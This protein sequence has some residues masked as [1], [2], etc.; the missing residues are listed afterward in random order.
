MVCTARADIDLRVE[1]RPIVQAI[2]AYVL[3][4]DGE[5]PIAGLA[6]GDFS[7]TLDGMA[8]AEYEFS[9]PPSQDPSQN[10]SIV[11]VAQTARFPSASVYNALIDELDVGDYVSVVKYQ[12][13]I[14]MSRSG[15]VEILAFT[16]VD[17]G[18]GSDALRAFLQS[19]LS[20]SFG[21]PV[22]FYQALLA[23]VGEFERPA[24]SLPDGPK[25]IV[26]AA[27]GGGFNSLSEVIASANANS[28][29]I[30]NVGYA[31]SDPYPDSVARSRSLAENTGGFRVPLP[32]E[33]S[34][35]GALAIMASWLENGYRITIP[36]D[37]VTDCNP[38]VL[39]V[40]TG[41]E[42]TNITF[43]RCDTTP[44]R[45]DFPWMQD[46]AVGTKVVSEAAIITGI[47]TAVPVNVLDGE[48]SIGCGSTF[49]SEPGWILPGESVC[50]RHTTAA[51]GGLEV[52]TLLIVGGEAAWFT[53]STILPASP[54]S[55]PP[56][57]PP[58]DDDDFRRRRWSGGRRGTPDVVGIAI[59]AAAR[60]SRD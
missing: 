44:E 10:V 50:L 42:T 20:Q 59:C 7:I 11:V 12:G 28:I 38:H 56:P 30:F 54:P 1:S 15:G 58:P 27:D 3:V 29:P 32:A 16:Q 49:T 19:S 34:L 60:S 21:R 8:L 25:A 13:D 18:A 39:E 51:S 2:E 36:Q 4:T 31:S 24:A 46:V 22:F 5:S 53:S 43:V 9:L 35:E 45:F 6:A 41:G 40:T 14:E 47:E 33:A 26:T 17:G 52:S 48:Y 37:A 23:G 57:P 55:S